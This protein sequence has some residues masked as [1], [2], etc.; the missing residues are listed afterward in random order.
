MKNLKEPRKIMPILLQAIIITFATGLVGLYDYS[1][2]YHYVKNGLPLPFLIQVINV[3][4]A[5][6]GV[7]EYV[8]IRVDSLFFFF[9]VLFWTCFLFFLRVLGM[10]LKRIFSPRIN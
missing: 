3:K 1:P 10:I 4:I 9:D 8:D 6:Y 7:A 2:P 5:E